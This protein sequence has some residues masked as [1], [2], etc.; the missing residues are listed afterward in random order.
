LRQLIPKFSDRLLGAEDAGELAR[1]FAPEVTAQ[2]LENTAKHQVYLKLAVDG[3]T[4]R[5]FSARTLPPA[6]PSVNEQNRETIIKVSREKY[7]MRREVIEDKI[8]RWLAGSTS[9]QK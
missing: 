9:P 2:D 6:T 1:E 7:A 4:S 3:L 8:T 5:P